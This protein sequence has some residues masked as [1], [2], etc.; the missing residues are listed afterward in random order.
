M[1]TETGI[2]NKHRRAHRRDPTRFVE[3]RQNLPVQP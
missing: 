1:H 3:L 2:E